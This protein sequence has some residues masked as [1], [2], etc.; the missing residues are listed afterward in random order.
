[1]ASPIANDDLRREAYVLKQLQGLQAWK[2]SLV[3]QALHTWF[4]PALRGNQ[5]I[6]P[7]E[8]TQRTIELAKRQWEFS[9]NHQY[10]SLRQQ[11]KKNFGAEF[12]ALL[13]HEYNGQVTEKDIEEMHADISRCFRNL[14]I[15][16]TLPQLLAGHTSLW[17]ERSLSFRVGDFPVRAKL[18]LLCSAG[19][20]HTIL[21]WKVSEDAASK[22]PKQALV[23]ALS[24]IRAL[25]GAKPEDLQVYEFNLLANGLRSHI[26][27][28][29]KLSD[30][31]DF[32]FR[33]ATE[34]WGLLG[35]RGPSI[36]A[37][38][39]CESASSPYTCQYCSFRKLCWE[40]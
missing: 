35:N 3:H 4:V 29:E 13:P 23:Y 24:V 16:D 12:C 40:A 18:D 39:D 10:R 9:R 38:E 14:G 2:G 33:S 27:T 11:A 21:D 20:H 31:E 1:M 19:N 37:L 28:E 7:D 17:S 36:E 8:L 34:I 26:V 6:T 15:C 25:P 30:T 5:K 32:I 22:N